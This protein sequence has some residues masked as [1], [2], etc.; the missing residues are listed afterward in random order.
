MNFTSN[1]KLGTRLILAFLTVVLLGMAVAGVGIN[2]LSRLNDTN[3]TNDILYQRELL[4]V[5]HIKEANIN[6]V[7]VGRARANFS[8]ATSEAERDKARADLETSLE[9]VRKYLTQAE[10]LFVSD[11]GRAMLASLNGDVES[12][13]GVVRVY[14]D[15]AAQLPLASRDEALIKL[16][17]DARDRNRTVDTQ[18]TALSAL[19]SQNAEEAAKAGTALYQSTSQLM[20]ALTVLS[21]LLGLGLGVLI[22]RGLTRQLGG[23]P[24]DVAD[25]ARA[26]AAGD[27]QT[28]IN[29]RRSAPGSVVAAMADMQASLGQIVAQVR[30]NSDS[31][32]TGSAQIATA[33]P[34]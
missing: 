6:L 3:D 17:Q 31:I 34:T 20:M 25:A 5:S 33:T 29:T 16:D 2:G 8:L 26:I 7:Y 24:G 9:G 15:A 30:Q 28:P 13:S 12:W 18:L 14:L 11:R 27:L 21:A 32:A 1:L 19:K 4:G 10:P 23:E 22:T